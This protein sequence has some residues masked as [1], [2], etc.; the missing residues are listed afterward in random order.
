MKSYKKDIKIAQSTIDIYNKMMTMKVDLAEINLPKYEII[1]CW[2]AE[3]EDGN[4]MDIRVNTSEDDVWC[5]AVLF[6]KDGH[7]LYV[8]D[9]KD[10]LDGIYE[11]EYNDTSYVLFVTNKEEEK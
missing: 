9:V 4:T 8:D 7:E 1:N 3:F 11:C 6:D 5:E 2:S 10:A